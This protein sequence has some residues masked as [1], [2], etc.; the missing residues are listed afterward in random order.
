M[1]LP[2]KIKMRDALV[3]ENTDATISDYAELLKEVEQVEAA[4]KINDIIKTAAC[5]TNK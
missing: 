2:D 1:N 3:A 4:T 5:S